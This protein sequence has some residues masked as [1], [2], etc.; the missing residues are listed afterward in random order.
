[1][2][3]DS[4]FHL[5]LIDKLGLDHLR[6][7][8]V[9][10]DTISARKWADMVSAPEHQ[11]RNDDPSYRKSF[12]PLIVMLFIFFVM[13]TI[14]CTHGYADEGLPVVHRATKDYI[15]PDH[16]NVIKDVSDPFELVNRRM[17]MFNALLDKVVY[18]PVLR[19]YQ[20][21]LPDSVEQCI[22]NFYNN[23][24]EIYTLANA[25]LQLKK[26]KSMTT[27]N[28]ILMNS[29]A[30]VLGLFDVATLYGLPRQYEDFGQT[31]GYYGVSPG[32][33]LMLPILG[34]SNVRDALGGGA[35]SLI[36]TAIDPFNFGENSAA[37]AIYH[38]VQ[39][40]DSRNQVFFRYYMTG[41]PFEYEMV[42]MLYD[43]SRVVEIDN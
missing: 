2:K 11:A 25:V 26:E 32:P 3:T 14:P 37:S 8:M 33:Y 19:T 36:F 31:L 16:P 20:M 34:P 29:T 9:G 7:Q 23:I 24:S 42:R 4:R 18:L 5:A 17:Y 15:D 28:R 21:V 10:A 39:I 41:S 22:S 35:E 27:F 12:Y 30:G 40:V 13:A 43:R 6:G 1:M 38:A